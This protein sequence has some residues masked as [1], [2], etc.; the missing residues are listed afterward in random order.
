VV[1]KTP[2]RIWSLSQDATEKSFYQAAK[3]G[4]HIFDILIPPGSGNAG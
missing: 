2:T 4:D 1:R 3:I